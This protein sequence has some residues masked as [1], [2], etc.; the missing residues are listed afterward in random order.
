MLLVD[1]LTNNKGWSF[2]G[3]VAFEAAHQLM[4]LGYDVIGLILIDAPSPIDHRPLP[5]E[6][7]SSVIKSSNSTPEANNPSQIWKEFD[8]NAA[9]L[10]SY[11]PSPFSKSRGSGL[12]T[13]YLRSQEV[14]DAVELC[15][16]TYDWLSNQDVRSDA[17]KAWEGLV[18]D[19]VQVLSIPGNHFEAFTPKNVGPTFILQFPVCRRC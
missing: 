4:A 13:V 12:K 11:D 17:I 2:G 18:G 6:I 16:V 7:I 19:H 3:V 15:G 5:K 10:G 14:L 9:L 1:D 8:R